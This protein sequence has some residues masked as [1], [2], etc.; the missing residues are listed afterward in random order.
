MEKNWK[1]IRGQCEAKFCPKW[2]SLWLY[3]T[4]TCHE[5]LENDLPL[6]FLGFIV[7]LGRI[8][9]TH[10]CAHH[11]HAYSWTCFLKTYITKMFWTWKVFTCSS[12][13]FHKTRQEC[14]A[15]VCCS[16]SYD[17]TPTWIR[18]FWATHCNILSLLLKLDHFIQ[19]DII[20]I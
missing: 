17:H 3:A 7:K 18:I 12:I 19:N 11:L 8:S 13:F 1:K 6:I 20:V 14:V 4:L 2:G 5:L 15:K 9:N 16:H 10:N